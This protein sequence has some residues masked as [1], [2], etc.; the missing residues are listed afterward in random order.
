[1]DR[2]L[3][4]SHTHL[5]IKAALSGMGVALVERRLIARELTQGTLIVPFG[6][7]RCPDGLAGASCSAVP[8]LD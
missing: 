2:R 1:V 7:A 8:Q 4:F 3:S 5:G 6:F